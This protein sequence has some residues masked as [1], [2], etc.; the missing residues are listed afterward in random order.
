MEEVNW[1]KS[2]T[3][4]VRFVLVQDV[5]L[6]INHLPDYWEKSRRS[7]RYI[8]L[9]KYSTFVSLFLVSVY[10]HVQVQLG[11]WVWLVLCVCLYVCTVCVHASMHIWEG[12]IMAAEY[13]RLEAV[14]C[15]LE[16]LTLY[17]L[18]A[19]LYSH[20]NDKKP[21]S[22]NQHTTTPFPPI[23]YFTGFISTQHMNKIYAFPWRIWEILP[24]P[25][26]KEWFWSLA[27]WVWGTFTACNH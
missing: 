15:T 18:R 6:C 26:I 14:G 5:I 9:V 22:Q 3:W 13:C 20:S 27:N 24:S 2:V 1:C 17:P 19:S 23:L 21:L 16:G 12:E 10:V 8:L 4:N 11:V 7:K 25:D